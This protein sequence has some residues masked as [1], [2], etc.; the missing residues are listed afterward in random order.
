MSIFGK[1][2]KKLNTFQII[3]IGFAAVILLGSLLLMLPFASSDG[4]VTPFKDTIFTATSAVCVTGLV[5]KDTATHWSYFGQA[6]ILILIQI[7][8]LGVV[9]VVASFS[10]LAGRKISLLERNTMQN[11]L[12]ANSVG[13]IVRMTRFII[14][15]SMF[16]EGV[17]TLAMMTVF[18]PAYG[19]KGIWM[20]AFHSVSAFCN[21]GFDIMGSET[22]KFSSLTSFASD[23]LIVIVV[24]LL[25]IIGG[26]GFLTW[27]DIVNHKFRIKR[28]RMQSK[29]VLTVSLVL[30]VVPALMFFLFDFRDMPMKER[31]L[32]S[33]FQAVTP[34]TAGFNT[35]DFSLMTGPGRMMIII[36]MLIGGSSG[37]TAGGMKTT[38]LGVLVGNSWSIITNKKSTR[39]FGRRIEDSVVR[40]AVGILTMYLLLAII[41]TLLIS[42]IEKLPVDACLFETVSALATVGLTLGITPELKLAS[43]FILII[44]MFTGRVGG[45]TVIFATVSRR[46]PPVSELPS[47]K[48]TVG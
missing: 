20:A 23:P 35:A 48:I 6:V 17:G 3:I 16:I 44:L 30:I 1:L 5:V 4:T 21:A 26:I 11:A 13:G 25:I 19:A 7:G 29:V 47:E 2:R 34:R 38:T 9:T 24:C 27:D 18:I 40:N 41:G 39:L 32:K 10:L 28:Y 43:R 36:L 8:G 31:L 14:R 46:K 42:T 37:S 22:G 45:L 15:V 12:S 33:I